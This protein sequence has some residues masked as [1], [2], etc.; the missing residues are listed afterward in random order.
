MGKNWKVGLV[1][2]NWHCDFKANICKEKGTLNPHLTPTKE[3]QFY[4]KSA[5]GTYW[6]SQQ[7]LDHFWVFLEP[8]GVRIKVILENKLNI[9]HHWSVLENKQLCSLLEYTNVWLL[10]FQLEIGEPTTLGLGQL[11]SWKT[12]I[13][14]KRSVSDC[15]HHHHLVEFVMPKVELSNTN[16]CPILISLF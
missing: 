13:C 10:T 6:V 8:I 3:F 15:H 14:P 2:V 5:H 4:R 16:K 9:Y 1:R 12:S 11:E 7:V